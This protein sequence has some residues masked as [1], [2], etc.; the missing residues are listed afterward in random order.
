M[1]RP[2]ALLRRLRRD[3]TGGALLEFGILAP[4]IF[5]LMIGV[6]Q[7]GSQMQNY[8]ALR[9]V[10]AE[11]ARYAIVQYQRTNRVS[12]TVMQAQ[13]ESIAS[14]LPY[15]LNNQAIFATV[16][17]ATSEISGVTKYNLTLTYTSPSFLG[18]IGIGNSTLTYTRPIYVP[19]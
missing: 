13:A 2:P 6:M 16:A 19:N 8:N 17:A 14:N 5:T 15:G 9:G 10:A 7:V 18:F 12:P 4:A 1:S 11:T 3:S